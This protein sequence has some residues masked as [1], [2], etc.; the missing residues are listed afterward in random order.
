[1]KKK[2]EKLTIKNVKWLVFMFLVLFT[3]AVWG[4]GNY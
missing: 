4:A 3:G 2:V 1:M